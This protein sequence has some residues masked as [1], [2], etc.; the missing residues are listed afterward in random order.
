VKG[1]STWGDPFIGS[2]DPQVRFKKRSEEV[3]EEARRSRMAMVQALT[4]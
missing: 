4:A 2:P 3:R 1:Q